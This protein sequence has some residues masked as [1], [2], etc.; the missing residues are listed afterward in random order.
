VALLWAAG[1]TSPAADDASF[2]DLRVEVSEHVPTV[3]TVAWETAGDEPDAAYVEYET[4]SLPAVRVD[5]A[6]SMDGWQALLFGLKPSTEY[7]F[8]AVVLTEGES[9][10]SDDHLVTTGA[11]LGSLPDVRVE[12]PEAAA[13]RGGYL[14]TS[15][16]STPSS[17]VIL[18]MDGD[19]VWWH[20][21]DEANL[22]SRRAVFSVDGESIIVLADGVSYTGED[23][24]TSQLRRVSLDGSEVSYVELESAHHDFVQ[25]SDGSLAVIQKDVKLIDGI[26]GVTGETILEVSPDGRTETVWSMW[27]ETEYEQG[28]VHLIPDD[29][30]LGNALDYDDTTGAYYMGTRNMG[31]IFA[32][33]RASSEVLWRLG[34]SFSDFETP[35][36]ETQLTIWQHQFQVFEDGILVFDNGDSP[37]VGTRIVEFALDHEEGVADT[38]WEYTRDESTFCY[39]LGDV[40]RFE[41]G[42]TLVTWSTSGVFEEITPDGELVWQMSMD[43]GAGLGYTTWVESLYDLIDPEA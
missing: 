31:T 11:R 33:D 16:I 38:R 24:H 18:D 19:Y 32:I 9:T 21:V 1:C 30:P 42:N 17:A 20:T 29:N 4:P 37:Y 25:L 26:V 8:R 34:G 27:D 28:N 12:F 3:L 14:I 41:D 15:T 36:G 6:R 23:D 43:L 39:A 2:A 10:V 22:S 5:A 7:T 40:T 13:E 35:D